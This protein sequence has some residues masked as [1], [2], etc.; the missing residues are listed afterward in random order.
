MRSESSLAKRFARV[1]RYGGIP[2]Q[3]PP[4]F[5]K[6]PY[7]LVLIPTLI[8]TPILL[9]ARC[10]PRCSSKPEVSHLRLGANCA[11]SKFCALA[12]TCPLVATLPEALMLLC[13]KFACTVDLIPLPRDCWSSLRVFQ[14]TAVSG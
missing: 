5:V 1:T 4:R 14:Q 3:P 10:P 6:T 2:R 8:L 9:A 11:C 7:F 12:A 13:L